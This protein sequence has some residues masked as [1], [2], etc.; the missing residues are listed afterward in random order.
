MP[1]TKQIIHFQER[2]SRELRSLRLHLRVGR[3]PHKSAFH[4]YSIET[5]PNEKRWKFS[6]VAKRE[7]RL[8]SAHIS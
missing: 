3:A 8:S 6:K 2:H 1:M 4:S 5:Q 7:S